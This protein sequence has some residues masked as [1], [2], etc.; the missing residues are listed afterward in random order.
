MPPATPALKYIPGSAGIDERKQ[1]EMKKKI[2]LLLALSM[3]AA[4]LVGCTIGGGATTTTAGSS[5]ST[6]AGSGATATATTAG[7]GGT[8][9]A[10]DPKIITYNIGYTPEHG[11][12][13]GLGQTTSSV[14]MFIQVTGYLYRNNLQ[15]EWVPEL[16]ESYTVSDDQLTWTFKL[17]PG[18]KFSSGNPITAEDVKYS[19]M[20]AIDPDMA[21]EYAFILEVIKGAVDFEGSRSDDSPIS[22]EAARDAV[23][24]EVIDDLT[25]AVTL[26]APVPYFIQLMGFCTYGVLDMKFCE[27]LK[28]AGKTYGDS[29]E[30]ASSSGPFK[31][32][33]YRIGEYFMTMVNENYVFAD[34]IKLDGVRYTVIEQSVTE[35]NLWETG[36]VDVTFVDMSSADRDK[37]D[38]EGKLTKVG[39]LGTQWFAFNCVR[40]PFDDPKVRMA[41]QKALDLDTLVNTVVKGG[42]LPA[43]G[44]IP[45]SMPATD[46]PTKPFRT[47]PFY[48]IKGEVEAAK[49]LLAEAGYPDGAGFPDFKVQYGVTSDANRA[50]VEAMCAMWKTNLGINGIPDGMETQARLDARRAGDFDITCQG[51]GADYADPYTFLETMKYGHFYNYGNYNN[52]A[53]DQALADSFAATTDKG[54]NDALVL[55]E[56]ILMEDA[57]VLMTYFSG[58][59][60]L[61]NPRVVDVVCSP[62]G[63]VDFRWAD[64]VE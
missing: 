53:F 45:R 5:T 39:I 17:R 14:N 30:N 10:A 13:P 2:A 41:L 44:F 24:I 42:Y 46:D 64:I 18:M 28:A 57:G 35:L 40:A 6:T 62:M 23:G 31:W 32:T 26:E 4:M 60:F 47:E 15:N 63:I 38:S 1:D 37:Y 49:A 9:P 3:I 34:E 7:G 22:Y 11:M 16:A 43:D 50:I 58:K 25:I 54:R 12:D 33:E 27:E 48:D 52:P 29:P 20:R 51:W 55:A 21:S 36:E 19:W 61:Q 8:A 59:T 56:K